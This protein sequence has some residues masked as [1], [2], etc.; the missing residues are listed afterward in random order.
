ME[1]G[2][3]EKLEALAERTRKKKLPVDWKETRIGSSDLAWPGAD[4]FIREMSTR[5][6]TRAKARN[7][8]SMAMD[9]AYFAS[10][11]LSDNIDLSPEGYL[12]ARNAVIGRTGFQTYKISEIADPEHLLD[13]YD[14]EEISLWRDPSEVFS[15]RTMASFEGKT[16]TIQHPGELLDPDSEQRHFAGHIQNVREGD[17]PLDDGNYPLL[18]DV[19]IK[20][21]EGIDAF[22]N[23][24]REL[25]CG[26]SYVL[27]K[28][29][30]RYEQR[31]ILGNHVALVPKARAGQEV[32]LTDAFL[33]HRRVGAIWRAKPCPTS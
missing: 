8:R 31:N 1:R 19:I 4:R 2:R 9:T 17:A 33:G 15:D 12:L 21:R 24:A 27:A 25:S 5:T 18:A 10:E 7:S 23:G 30:H 14:R 20:T 29:G 28:E 11:R 32:R 6:R 26:Y 16:L 3:D 22:R 13:N